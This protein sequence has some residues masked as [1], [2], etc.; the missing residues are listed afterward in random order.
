MVAWN[1]SPYG[2]PQDGYGY[3]G[4]AAAAANELVPGRSKQPTG[5]RLKIMRCV[6]IKAPEDKKPLL[7]IG[8]GLGLDLDSQVTGESK[9]EELWGFCSWDY[10]V[11]C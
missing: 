7:D 11:C 1:A 6:Q 8:L 4:A 10:L 9:Q 3:A 5:A 2:S